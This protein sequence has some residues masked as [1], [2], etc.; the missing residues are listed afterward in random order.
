MKFLETRN[1]RAFYS[2]ILV[3]V[4]LLLTAAI[5]CILYLATRTNQEGVQLPSYSLK[6]E[7]RNKILRDDSFNFAS[8]CF[9]S[10]GGY[11]CRPKI[12]RV[13]VNPGLFSLVNM[14]SEAAPGRYHGIRVQINDCSGKS[15]Y[16]KSLK[17]QSKLMFDGKDYSVFKNVKGIKI[18]R[19]S[20]SGFVVWDITSGMASFDLDGVFDVENIPK[21]PVKYTSA[22]LFAVLFISIITMLSLFGK[23]SETAVSNGNEA[24]SPCGLENC[25]D[26]GKEGIS[27]DAVPANS[28]RDR[29]TG[30]MS[31][32]RLAC[33]AAM[34]F[35]MLFIILSVCGQL[36][37]FN[38][39]SVSSGN[40]ESASFM[41]EVSDSPDFSYS[42]GSAG[43]YSVRGS[44]IRIPKIF[45]N[46]RIT[47]L[48]EG[49]SL[50]NFSFSNSSGSCRIKNNE[51][52]VNGG[53][54]CRSDSNGRMYV[55]FGSTAD[56]AANFLF[57]TIAAI[58]VSGVMYLMFRFME[59]KSAIRLML[60]VIMISAYITG[61][62]CMNVEFC[63]V[64]F[65]KDYLQ[66]LPDAVLKN[67]CLILLIFLLAELPVSRGF[68]TS[69]TFLFALLLV[70]IYVA[71]DWG[72]SGNFGVR[73]DIRTVLSHI[74]ADNSTFFSFVW[75]FFRT[76]HASW[77]VLVMLADWVIMQP[78]FRQKESSSTGKYLIMLLVLNCIPFLKVYE[79]FYTESNYQ[80]R[81]DIF[82]IQSDFLADGEKKYTEAFPEYNWKPGYQTID[83]L[84]RRK[85]V[86][87]LCV[88]SLADSYSRYFSGLRGY[89][90]N[91]DQLAEQNASF[92]NYH[93]T[94]ME[95]A[96]ATYS[97]LTGKIFFSELDREKP[98]FSFEYGEAL[99][100]IMNQNGYSTYAVYSSMDFGGLDDIYRNSGF[101]HMYGSLD[102]A[103]SGVE[104]YHFGSV[105]DSVLLKHASDLIREFDHAG[106][107]HFTFIMTSSSHTPFL[108]PDTGKSGYREVIPYVDKEIGKFVRQLEKDGFFKNG[109]LIITGDHHPPFIGLEPG[110]LEKYSDD[111][112]RVPLIIIDRD[113]GQRRFTNVFGHDSLK[114]IIEYLNLKKVRKYDYQL[115][116]LW[117][118]EEERSVTV[119]CP[120]LFQ[121]HYLG[122]VR[123]SGPNGEQ[124]VYD[125]NGD[126]SE[127]SGSFLEPA[128][129]KEVAGR[130]KW[131]K[132]EE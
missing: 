111:L 75:A 83:G 78:S 88:E 7:V 29:V 125:A 106:K 19:D 109:T 59:F 5:S 91:I 54:S 16:V 57:A 26:A 102:P 113:I 117:E 8:S 53:L 40:T 11:S 64:L 24:V 13:T 105:A 23:S 118:P 85:N 101:G 21:T 30:A 107:P 12:T 120:M 61:E 76:S 34:V 115:I 73:A 52:E 22:L 3:V 62:I 100:K 114:S 74:G 99:P 15:L 48:T 86:V 104:R 38:E 130:V 2:R 17:L 71:V 94:G 45:S 14:S 6:L 44:Q 84:N 90:P 70:I 128:L 116:P 93:S 126:Y 108:N 4:L 9:V 32:A 77:M 79:N 123:V 60:T 18:H 43:F 41:A 92:L 67:I 37:R 20:E 97:M 82:D 66:L 56:T 63:N 42:A 110:E 58:A 119:L 46:M 69:D 122:G 33:M 80:L 121:N 25:H 95:T 96:P 72:V 132:R 50:S 39:F 28:G 129:E 55:N 27:A 65:Y 127:F 31:H 36:F 103:Y 10:D 68:L 87:I 124:G 1:P 35:A 131:F 51:I 89:M 112:N 81:K 98:D 47:E 49:E